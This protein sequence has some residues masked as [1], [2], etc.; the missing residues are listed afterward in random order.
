MTK[1]HSH[2]SDD[3][4]IAMFY[5]DHALR[6]DDAVTIARRD[7]ARRDDIYAEDTLAWTL[8]ADGRWQEA[9]VHSERAVRLGTEDAKLQYHAGI[10]ALHCGDR[11]DARRRL[12]LALSL[13]PHFNPFQVRDASRELDELRAANVAVEL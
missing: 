6:A 7:L 4:L 13:N 9:R 8:A 2:L 5:A 11:D 12:Q 10:I 3:R 1:G